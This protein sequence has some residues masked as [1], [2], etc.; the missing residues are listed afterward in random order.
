MKA[1]YASLQTEKESPSKAST[2]SPN[3]K[4]TVTPKFGTKRGASR[5][6]STPRSKKSR[7]DVS[8]DSSSDSFHSDSSSP[9]SSPWK[10][11][12]CRSPSVYGQSQSSISSPFSAPSSPLSSGSPGGSLRLILS[13]SSWSDSPETPSRSSS[14]WSPGPSSPRLTPKRYVKKKKKVTKQNQNGVKS[15]GKGKGKAKPPTVDEILL[16][17]SQQYDRNTG[18]LFNKAFGMTQMKYRVFM[19]QVNLVHLANQS[20]SWELNPQKK[21][22]KIN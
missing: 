7:L 9:L 15:A 1:L 17:V 4:T 14:I 6:K 13:T 22:L 16:Q 11:S 19:M 2:S 8:S 18:K 20:L 21:A 3:E 12:E 5:N 10:R